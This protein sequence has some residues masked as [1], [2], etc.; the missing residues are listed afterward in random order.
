MVQLRRLHD[1]ADDVLVDHKPVPFLSGHPVDPALDAGLLPVDESAPAHHRIQPDLPARREKAV[2]LRHI[3]RHSRLKG[4]RVHSHL[5]GLRHFGIDDQFA[6]SEQRK[7]RGRGTRIHSKN[8]ERLRTLLITHRHEL[9][10]LRDSD[11]SGPESGT[12]RPRSISRHPLPW[13]R[14]PVR[15]TAGSSSNGNPVKPPYRER[16]H[17][18]IPNL[19]S[20]SHAKHLIPKFFASERFDR[21]NNKVGLQFLCELLLYFKPFTPPNRNHIL[22]ASP[23]R[24][25]SISQAPFAAHRNDRR[26]PFGMADRL[27]CLPTKVFL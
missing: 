15:P 27:W 4:L 21:P 26:P 25:R 3:V 1:P 9:P 8:M 23:V 12:P 2:D 20:G 16:F 10:I 7:L 13:E 6:I 19:E 14:L 22:P 18:S 5:A 11:T 17:G 24:L